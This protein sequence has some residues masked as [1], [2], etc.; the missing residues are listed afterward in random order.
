MGLPLF[1]GIRNFPM[2]RE[3]C[4]WGV[5]PP[6]SWPAGAA[7]PGW[8]GGGGPRHPQRLQSSAVQPPQ[9]SDQGHV[10][11]PPAEPPGWLPR[12]CPH[13]PETPHQGPAQP[14]YPGIVEPPESWGP[15]VSCQGGKGRPW[16]KIQSTLR[17]RQPLCLSFPFSGEQ[18]V[19]GGEP[20]ARSLG[21]FS[22]S[23]PFNSCASLFA[24]PQFSLRP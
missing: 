1:L 8:E 3:R 21:P 23:F 18:P 6:S 17:A 14:G 2:E 20:S 15:P 19:G 13:L 12:E 7:D 16:G 24:P 4:C 22:C 11:H 5:S 10:P 9:G